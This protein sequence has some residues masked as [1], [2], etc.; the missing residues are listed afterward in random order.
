RRSDRSAALSRKTI[1]ATAR[2]FSRPL[3]MNALRRLDL[4]WRR[5]VNYVRIIGTDL[6]VQALGRVSEQH[7]QGAQERGPGERSFNSLW[8]E[9][10]G[11]FACLREY[12]WS[13]LQPFLYPAYNRFGN[14]VQA[15]IDGTPIP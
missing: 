8:C 9:L 10:S 4:S 12:M 5:G 1:S 15:K 7:E 2:H 11:H 3:R 13:P 6:L 14:G